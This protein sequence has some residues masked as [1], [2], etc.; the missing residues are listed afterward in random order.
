M[1]RSSGALQQK[2]PDRSSST[3][4]IGALSVASLIGLLGLWLATQSGSSLLE[5]L[6][7]FHRPVPRQPS[8]SFAEVVDTSNQITYKGVVKGS[9][10]HF[11]NV[12][13]GEDTSGKNRFAPPKPYLA[14]PGSVVDATAPGA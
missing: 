9:F 11:Q 3:I 4:G 5:I 7:T 1:A 6:K 14:S 10:E 8:A 13:Y 2:R 12:F